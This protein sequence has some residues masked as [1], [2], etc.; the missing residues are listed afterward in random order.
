MAQCISRNVDFSRKLLFTM[1]AVAAIA[2]PVF[3]GLVVL[4][5]VWLFCRVHRKRNR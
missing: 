1:A 2:A 3:F 5:R 4:L